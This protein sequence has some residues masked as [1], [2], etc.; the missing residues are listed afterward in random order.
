MLERTLRLCEAACG[1]LWTYDGE[2]FQLVGK[3]HV[4]PEFDELLSRAGPLRPQKGSSLQ[5]LM[6]GENLMQSHDRSSNAAPSSAI[7]LQLPSGVA[8]KMISQS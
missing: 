1:T 6:E 7:R 5:R 2:A 8:V 3:R 4:P